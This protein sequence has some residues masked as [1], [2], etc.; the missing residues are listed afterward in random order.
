[1]TI[2]PE[3]RETKKKEK[4]INKQNFLQFLSEKCLPDL[5]LARSNGAQREI[6]I[7]NCARDSGFS[8]KRDVSVT[9]SLKKFHF[10]GILAEIDRSF[11]KLTAQVCLS[12]CPVKIIGV[13]S[14]EAQSEKDASLC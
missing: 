8:D 7:G 14:L 4:Q 11:L 12:I 2:E 13:Q 9:P 1:M 6:W 10:R 5:V 3:C